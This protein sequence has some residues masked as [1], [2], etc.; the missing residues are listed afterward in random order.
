MLVHASTWTVHGLYM[1]QSSL[2]VLQKL[3]AKP[4][5]LRTG[6]VGLVHFR[7]EANIE[8]SLVQSTGLFLSGA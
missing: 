4:N 2:D 7:N 5:R 8:S 6:Q 1:H 3:E